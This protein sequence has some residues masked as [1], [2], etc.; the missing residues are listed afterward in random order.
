M[1]RC[2]DCNK[3][4]LVTELRAYEERFVLCVGCHNAQVAFEELAA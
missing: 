4:D 2:R 3:S 1:S